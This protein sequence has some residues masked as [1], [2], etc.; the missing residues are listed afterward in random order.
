MWQESSSC[1]MVIL[2][3]DTSKTKTKSFCAGG[4]VVALL[5]EK[6]SMEE[7]CDFFRKEYSL[8]HLIGTFRKPIIS[9]LDGITSN[10]KLFFNF[11]LLEVNLSF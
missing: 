4:D 5:D 7:R 6:L 9:L 3:S 8:N 1:T 11:H 10:L 2:K